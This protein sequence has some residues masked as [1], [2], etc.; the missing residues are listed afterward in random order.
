MSGYLPNTRA[1]P[2]SRLATRTGANRWEFLPAVSLRD[3]FGNGPAPVVPSDRLAARG[4][5]CRFAT[6]GIGFYADRYYQFCRFS[7]K[8]G[9][10]FFSRC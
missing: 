3:E 6:R 1:P 8:G 7:S 10:A 5:R 2:G 4:R 9:V